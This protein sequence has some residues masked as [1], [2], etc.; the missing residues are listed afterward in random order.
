MV[1]FRFHQNGVAIVTALHGYDL[2]RVEGLDIIKGYIRIEVVTHFLSVSPHSH[3]VEDKKEL[4]SESVHFKNV[5]FRCCAQLKKGLKNIPMERYKE[6]EKND[7]SQE[8]KERRLLWYLGRHAYGG[9]I[10]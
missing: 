8:E 2:D 5:N 6:P 1:Y 7:F 10:G 3:P 9:I 4:R